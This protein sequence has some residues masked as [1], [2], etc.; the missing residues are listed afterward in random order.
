MVSLRTEG[1]KRVAGAAARLAIL[2]TLGVL[3]LYAPI[4]LWLLP[5]ASG[6]GE[7]PGL[8][9]ELGVFAA[10]SFAVLVIARRVGFLLLWALLLWAWVSNFATPLRLGDPNTVASYFILWTVL[11]LPLYAI[12][13][14]GGSERV[15][16]RLGARRI[17]LTEA[18]ALLWILLIV[19]AF[20]LVF[21]EPSMSDWALLN[22]TAR[23]LWKPAPFVFALLAL[24][25]VWIPTSDVSAGG[26]TSA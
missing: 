6:L 10:V 15:A 1:V 21:V 7:L 17:R 2:Y 25:S 16:L 26:L 5:H 9:A 14:L 20:V 8:S 19:V 12:A 4:R 22:L 23:F 11:A 13:A 3:V 24:A 18:G